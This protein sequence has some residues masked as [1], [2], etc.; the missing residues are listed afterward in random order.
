M[1][2]T[3]KHGWSFLAG[4]GSL[5]LVYVHHGWLLLLTGLVAGVALAWAF[6]TGWRIA[7][8]LNRALPDSDRVQPVEITS[9]EPPRGVQAQRF[10]L[11]DD[12]HRNLSLLTAMMPRSSSTRKVS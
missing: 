4:A 6:R 12:I 3:F 2:A 8:R 10:E 5:G 9:T 1:K 7:G 11:L